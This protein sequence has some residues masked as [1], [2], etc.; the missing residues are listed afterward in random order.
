MHRTNFVN[1]VTNLCKG[2]KLLCVRSLTRRQRWGT[3]TSLQPW[4]GIEVCN[5]ISEEDS[6]HCDKRGGV[7][8]TLK[9]RDVK[10]NQLAYS[11]L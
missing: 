8:F 2:K 3:V 7:N 1:I 10:S 4:C 9:S 5:V 11:Q 6:G